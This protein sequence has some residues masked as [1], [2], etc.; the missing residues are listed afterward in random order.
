[1]AYDNNACAF[2]GR[3]TCRGCTECDDPP[4]EEAEADE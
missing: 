4:E 1:M 2:T 3:L